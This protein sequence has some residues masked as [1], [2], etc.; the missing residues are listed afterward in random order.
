MN[1]RKE[2][3]ISQEKE[4]QK[5]GEPEQGVKT[6]NNQNNLKTKK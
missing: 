5:K 1:N 6:K 2:K 4:E 3:N